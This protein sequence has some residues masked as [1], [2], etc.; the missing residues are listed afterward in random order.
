MVHLHR[1]QRVDPRPGATHQRCTEGP[2]NRHQQTVPSLNG[3]DPAGEQPGKRTP[4]HLP[5][6]PD[7]GP[8]SGVPVPLAGGD[9][10]A[11]FPGGGGG[12]VGQ[13]QKRSSQFTAEPG[14]EPAP[15]NRTAG[16]G[17]SDRRAGSHHPGT[18]SGSGFSPAI[19]SKYD[20]SG[21]Q[22]GRQP[23]GR[24]ES[25][26][27]GP[28][29]GHV[30]FRR[31]W[32]AVEH[33]GAA[34]VQ[35]RSGPPGHSGIPESPVQASHDFLPAPVLCRCAPASRIGTVP[36]AN[37]GERGLH[38]P[39]SFRHRVGVGCHAFVG[40]GPG[41]AGGGFP[42][43][44]NPTAGCQVAGLAVHLFRRSLGN[45]HPDPD[46]ARSAFPRLPGRYCDAGRGPGG[47]RVG[48]PDHFIAQ[49]AGASPLSSGR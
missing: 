33:V 13:D 18:V 23:S 8:G 36:L 19:H 11:V 10:N 39:R 48:V 3:I 35:L 16:L 20:R 15:G 2:G 1:H 46:G 34:Y 41:L 32:R 38:W 6:K 31:D 42:D 49:P 17:R 28:G 40:A 22:S 21:G 30:H 7:V 26:I 25:I 4:G 12:V 43:A 29:A 27:G 24:R 5:A 44:A 37:P 45:L 9:R 14:S 47:V